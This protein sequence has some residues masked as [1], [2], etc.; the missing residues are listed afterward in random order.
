MVPHL[1]DFIS[2]LQT[3]HNVKNKGV[4]YYWAAPNNIRRIHNPRAIRKT[5]PSSSC[6]KSTLLRNTCAQPLKT[7]C[8]G[9]EQRT[10]IQNKPARGQS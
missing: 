4:E 2:L 8:R 10:M 6:K 3:Q 1:Q 7:P 9:Y 5:L